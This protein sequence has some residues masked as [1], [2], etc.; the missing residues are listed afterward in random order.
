MEHDT[1]W[2]GLSLTRQLQ[3]WVF[4]SVVGAML[5]VMLERMAINFLNR[6][7]NGP[8]KDASKS[9]L[10]FERIQY[11]DKTALLIA[12]S[13][14]LVA[15]LS[16]VG[17][18][19]QWT[20]GMGGIVILTVLVGAAPYARDAS[21][22]YSAK[23]IQRTAGWKKGDWIEQ[24]NGRSGKWLGTTLS[25]AILAPNEGGLIQTPLK[26]FMAMGV[27]NRQF[28]RE[29]N[30]LGLIR[31]QAE[32]ILIPNGP[33]ELTE[34]TLMELAS[35]TPGIIE[36]PENGYP[37]KLLHHITHEGH[38]M[39]LRY[40]VIDHE[41]DV[42][43]R[44]FLFKEGAK[45]LAL[46]EIYLASDYTIVHLSAE[47]IPTAKAEPTVQGLPN[48]THLSVNDVMLER[49]RKAQVDIQMQQ[50][51]AAQ[52][53]QAQAQALAQQQAA[54]NAQQAAAAQQQQQP[55]PV[56]PL[57]ET[58]SVLQPPIVPNVPLEQATPVDQ[59]AEGETISKDGRFITDIN[60]HVRRA[61]AM[62]TRNKTDEKAADT[63]PQGA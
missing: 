27:H 32:F 62:V 21:I 5:I 23:V 2:V 6:L 1:W 55:T 42:D 52:Q 11:K 16:I 57:T 43:T 24:G 47:H 41:A 7:I 4:G 48:V 33:V 39:T 22:F 30:Q 49:Q 53:Q 46:N 40:W 60:G 14:S 3:W 9:N 51:A 63:T 61:K 56:Q 8:T 29:D 28:P 54:F 26:E 50:A 35:R 19:S 31:T 36:D 45:L 44:S 37:I 15:L 25:D 17:V 12:I 18:P 59:L 13:F 38:K 34:K 20:N 10:M 58:P